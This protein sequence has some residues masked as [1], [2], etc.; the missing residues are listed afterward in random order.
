MAMKTLNQRQL[1]DEALD[2]YVDWREESAAVWDAYQRW[3]RASDEDG[4]LAFSGYRAAL[5]REESASR[6]YESRVTEIAPAAHEALEVLDT[7]PH[8]LW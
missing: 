8:A 4:G 7:A 3:A 5:D 2:A 1:V 6:V